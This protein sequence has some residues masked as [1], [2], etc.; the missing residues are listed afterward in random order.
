MNKKEIVDNAISF[1]TS[2]DYS[3]QTQT[4]SMLVFESSKREAN[5]LVVIILCCIGIIPGIIYYFG[6]SPKHKVT[7]SITSTGKVTAT[8]N[9]DQAK[10]DAGEF[11]ESTN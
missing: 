4:D 5:W 1:F 10:K 6:F 8:G 2:K 11:K 9:T 7:I 3:I